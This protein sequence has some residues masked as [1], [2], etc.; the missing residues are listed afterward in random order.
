[1][2][3]G[4]V[5]RQRS[6]CRAAGGRYSAAVRGHCRASAGAESA[7]AARRR[8]FPRGWPTGSGQPRRRSCETSMWC[9]QGSQAS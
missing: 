6:T 4:A 9:S 5:Q 2:L 8:P 7:R 3:P 1:M